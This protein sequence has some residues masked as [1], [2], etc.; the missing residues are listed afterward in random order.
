MKL[1]PS[2]SEGVERRGLNPRRGP[3]PR[4]LCALGLRTRRWPPTRQQ[5][6]RNCGRCAR[7]RATF[8]KPR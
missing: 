2:R 8:F 1:F 5:P 7:R 3:V 4:P 6:S